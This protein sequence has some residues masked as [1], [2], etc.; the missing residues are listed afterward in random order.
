LRGTWDVTSFF[1]GDAISSP[2]AGSSQT[3]T[4]GSARVSGNGGCNT[5]SG[6]YQLSGAD[7]IGIGPLAQT[8]RGC[9]YGNAEQQYVAALGLATTYQVTGHRLTLFR[10]GGTIAATFERAPQ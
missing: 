4:F 10:D 3:L 9:P 1:T 6:A 8:Q 7:G 5:F 2:P